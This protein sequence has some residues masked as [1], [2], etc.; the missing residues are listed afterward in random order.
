M[1]F[2]NFKKNFA[3]RVRFLR[4]ERKIS[5]REMSLSL[6]QNVNY[7]NYIEN[8]K[9]LPSMQGFFSICEYFDLPP[10]EFFKTQTGFEDITKRSENITIFSALTKRE[11]RSVVS[12]ILELK[13]L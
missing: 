13:K 6:G 10:S 11:Q 9:H 7:I 5:A 12:M 2:E 4:N 1:D 3:D 8:G